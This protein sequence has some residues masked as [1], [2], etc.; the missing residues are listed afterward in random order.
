MNRPCVSRSIDRSVRAPK[1]RHQVPIHRRLFRYQG[2]ST[3]FPTDLA[4]EPHPGGRLLVVSD[5]G[6]VRD[7][8][9]SLWMS[10]LLL[11]IFALAA[12]ARL[13]TSDLS[14]ALK[15]LVPLTI[16]GAMF[17]LQMALLRTETRKI[18][19]AMTDDGKLLLW[20][21]R[22]HR[23]LEREQ[24]SFG[25]ITLDSLR[26]SF[27]ARCRHGVGVYEG[28]RLL[29]PV[30]AASPDSC[31]GVLRYLGSFFGTAELRDPIAIGRELGGK[32]PYEIRLSG[33]SVILTDPVFVA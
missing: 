21:R 26:G 29:F 25:L 15:I 12:L 11:F 13:P 7:W 20:T 28:D 14:L 9:A 5:R 6:K 16:V 31:Q 18:V 1:P 2:W 27:T 17:A 8:R 30:L 19:L 4:L 33:D 23:G 3:A 22:G 10:G 24:I 32:P